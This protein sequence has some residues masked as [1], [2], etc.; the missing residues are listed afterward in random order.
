[1][2]KSF[3]KLT[4]FVNIFQHSFHHYQHISYFFDQG[5]A[6]NSIITLKKVLQHGHLVF[7]HIMP[8]SAYFL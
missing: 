8:L 5:N 3:T 6:D 7:K 2:E 4:P 1:M